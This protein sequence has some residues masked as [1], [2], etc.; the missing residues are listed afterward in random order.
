MLPLSLLLQPLPTTQAQRGHDSHQEQ[1]RHQAVHTQKA[2]QMGHQELPAVQGQDRLHTRCR[3]LHQLGQ[4]PPMAVPRICGSVFC[5]LMENLQVTKVN[6][7][8][9]M[10]H[11]YNSVVLFLAPSHQAVRPPRSFATRRAKNFKVHLINVNTSSFF[12]FIQ[13]E[14]CLVRQYTTWPLSLS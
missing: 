10:D 7:F 14:I 12:R 13:G 4:G 6:T 11:F 5:R 2:G 9:F 3:N 1:L 8:L